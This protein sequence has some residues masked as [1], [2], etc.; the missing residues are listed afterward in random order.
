MRIGKIGV[1]NKAETA[2]KENAFM[3]LDEAYKTGVR[4]FNTAP[5]YGKGEQVQLCYGFVW[6]IQ[7]LKRY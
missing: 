2:F 3:A 1:C 5:S 4:Y 6:I 7:V